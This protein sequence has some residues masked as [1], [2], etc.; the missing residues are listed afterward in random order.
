MAKSFERP[1]RWQ[2]HDF[3]IGNRDL[4]EGVDQPLM[5]QHQAKARRRLL[6]TESWH[7]VDEVGVAPAD[8]CARGVDQDPFPSTGR[9]PESPRK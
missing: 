1:Y 7:D 4:R 2:R 5:A 9:Y 8:A 6:G 3:E